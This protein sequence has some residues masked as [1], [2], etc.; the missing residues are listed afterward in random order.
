MSGKSSRKASKGSKGRKTKVEEV[1]EVAA[2]EEVPD[3]VKEVPETAE[4]VPETVEE[5]PEIVE[6]VPVPELKA[7]NE[8]PVDDE[9]TETA[10]MTDIQKRLFKVRMRMNQGR[11][12]NRKEVENEYKRFSDPKFEGKQRYYEKQEELKK[13]QLKANKGKEIGREVGETGDEGREIV[14]GAG[15][16]AGDD[17]VML[18]TAA[19]AERIHE[20]AMIKEKNMQTFG[21]Q[22]L[23]HRL[24]QCI[25]F[26]WLFPI[27]CS[28]F[29]RRIHFC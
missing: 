20:K 11:K 13:A 23:A 15:G 14:V 3:T 21:L 27:Q 19:A 8:E 4:D 1:V 26:N 22:V 9:E 10:G 25:N 7:V 18:I 12:V 5:V 6:E 29:R 28:L 24:R 2:V 17:P 16:V